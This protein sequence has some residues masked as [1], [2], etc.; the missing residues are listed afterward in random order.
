[1]IF[2]TPSTAGSLTTRFAAVCAIAWATAVPALANDWPQWRGP[3][4]DGVSAE[5]GIPIRWGGGEN[6][7][8]RAPLEGLGTSTPIIWADRIFVTSQLGRGGIDERGARFANTRRP[9]LHDSGDGTI[10]LVVQAFRLIDGELLW[11]F[12]MP[13][14]GW[15]PP[16]HRKHNLASPSVVTDG[17][18][19]YAWFGNGQVAALTVDGDLAWSRH[20]GEEYARFDVLWGHGSSPMLYDDTVVLLCD[21]P[22][23]GYLLALD[24]WTGEERWK[25]DRGPGLRSYSTPFLVTTATRD[26]L[27]VNSANRI[28]AYDPRSAELLWHAGGTVSLAIAM[29]VYADGVLYTSRGYASGPYLAIRTG[30]RGD[31]SASHIL[32]QSPTRAPYISSLLLYDGLLYMATELGIVSATDAADGALVW[33]L[34]LDGVFTASPVA[35]DGHVYFLG[36][37]GETFVIAAGREPTVVARNPIGERSLASPAISNGRI[38]IRTDDH[39]VAIGPP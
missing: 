16:V 39:L 23:G 15:V 24:R 33:R 31:V 27:I 30:G 13:A 7:A 20:I 12:A 1:M 32:W 19:V 18:M 34:R 37:S 21:H 36:E 9:K 35:A 11:E 22:P 26:E 10:T 8:W 6:I 3:T 5:T 25:V 17:E 2:S 29:P 14:E 28:D 4:A 38:F